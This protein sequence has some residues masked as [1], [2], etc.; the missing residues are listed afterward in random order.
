MAFPRFASLLVGVCPQLHRDARFGVRVAQGALLRARNKPGKPV[1]DRAT[2]GHTRYLRSHPED[3][4]AYVI[5]FIPLEV[6][7]F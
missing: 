5:Q 6:T 7:W 1:V 3:F 2:L 4:L